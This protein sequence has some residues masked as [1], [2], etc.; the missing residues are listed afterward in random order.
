MWLEA[1]ITQEDL[2]QVVQ[3]LLP[4]K[5]HLNHE[6]EGEPTPPERWLLLHPATK[7]VLVPDQGLR[8][9]CPAELRWSIAGMSPTL[10]LDELGVLIRPRVVDESTSHVLEFQFEVGEAD[11]HG[12]PQFIDATIVKAINRALAAKK[13]RWDFARTLTR[14]VAL[15][16]VLDPVE[17]LKIE[18]LWGKHRIG[19]E[20]LTFIVSF[21]IGFVRGD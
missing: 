11:L 21:K 2:V 16:S 8:V 20:A 5:I 3:E 7:V 6:E 14:T 1:I 15:P 18:V 12:F 10:K 17:T 9:T 13:L 19:A 4:V